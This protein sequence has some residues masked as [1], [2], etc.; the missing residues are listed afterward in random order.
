MWYVRLCLECGKQFETGRKHH[1]I[2]SPDCR[3]SYS[4]RI[5]RTGTNYREVKLPPATRGALSELLASSDLMARG[6]HVFRALSPACPC[7]LVAIHPAGKVLRIEVRTGAKKLKGDIGFPRHPS[8][9]GKSDLY[10][11]VLWDNTITYVPPLE[12]IVT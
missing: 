12:S 5:Y 10:A 6:Y 8:D 1:S 3:R 9:I 11:V 7:D 2:C 4:K